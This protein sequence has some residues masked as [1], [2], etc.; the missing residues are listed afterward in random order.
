MTWTRSHAGKVYVGLVNTEINSP[1]QVTFRYPGA[2]G[3]FATVGGNGELAR[4]KGGEAS[5]RLGPAG[6]L[7]VSAD[8]QATPATGRR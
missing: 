4:G 8:A 1:A 7:V 2:A 6:V 3:E 5:V